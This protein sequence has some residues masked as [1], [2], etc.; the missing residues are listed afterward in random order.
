VQ[1][2]QGTGAQMVLL[3]VSCLAGIFFGLYYKFLVLIPLTLAAAITC[4][5]AALLHGQTISASLFAIVV[6]AVGLQGGFMIGLTGRDLLSQFVSRLSGVQ[7][8][9]V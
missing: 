1:K 4:S 8:K 3:I 5:A 9:R 6:P 7:S 2:T